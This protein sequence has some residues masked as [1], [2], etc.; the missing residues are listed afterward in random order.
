MTPEFV[1]SPIYRET[2]YRG[3]HPLAIQ[4]IGSVLTL[5]EQLGWL[6]HPGYL[7]SPAA[8]REQLLQFHD[9]AYLDALIAADA[10]G[11]AHPQERE[12]YALGTLENPIFPGLYQRAATSVGGSILAAERAAQRRTVYH[13]SGGTHHALHNRASGFCF[14]ND[15][16]FAVLT[17]LQQGKQRVLY[18]DLDA[19]HG[20][21]VEAAFAGDER[22]F[23][24]STHEA[25]RWPFTGLVEDRAGGNARNLPVPR[26]LNDTEMDR[27]MAEAVLP[28]A[29][30]FAPDAVVI[31]CG[32]DP[33]LGD[34]LS[35]L[36]LSNTCLWDA[37]MALVGLVPS[38]VVLGGGGYNPWTVA[39]CWT[40]LWGRIAGLTIPDRLPPASV[41]YLQSLTSDLVDDEDD[42][43]PWWHETLADPRNDGPVRPEIDTLIRTVLA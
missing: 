30:R 10:R 40:G 28:L 19:H 4:R 11:K 20:D 29:R 7:D 14:F 27:I 23:L 2:G 26:N 17:L 18:V 42:M 34:P 32:A 37:V 15:P 3:N 43:L 6:P 24:I 5:C 25:N 35:S 22:V 38:A 16:V 31:T 12:T 8:T 41:A 39:R 21:G 13:P 9:A 1:S 36:E 33:L